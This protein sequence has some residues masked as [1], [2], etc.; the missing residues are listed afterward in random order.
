VTTTDPQAAPEL[1]K[2]AVRAA[3]RAL[4]RRFGGRP[5]L[6]APEPLE[7]RATV[8]RC[9]TDGKGL[10]KSVVVKTPR[11]AQGQA[12]S[13]GELAEGSPAWLL[14]TEWASL[15]F[16]DALQGAAAPRISPRLYGGDLKAG[17][18]VLE[19]LGGGQSLAD[20][21]LGDDA[22]AALAAF[23]AFGRSLG[24]MHAL[25]AGREAEYAEAL[26]SLGRAPLDRTAVHRRLRAEIEK[27]PATFDEFEFEW[28]PGMVDDVQLV[29]ASMLEPGPRRA[30]THGDPCPDNDRL[31][32]GG[33]VLLDFERAGFR[34]AAV[35]GAYARVPFPTCWCTNRMPEY[36]REGF[37]TAYRL[38]LMKGVPEAGDDAFFERSLTEAAGWWLIANANS[39][40]PGALRFERR[41]GIST[42]RQRLLYRFE[43]FSRLS[44]KSG[45]LEALG[46]WAWLM[47]ERMKVLWPEVQDMPVYPAFRKSAAE[48]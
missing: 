43:E 8:F 36:V 3:E 46:T 31:L 32:D 45:Y 14:T 48:S 47:H 7:E 15:E 34:S 20:A 19:D 26:E 16:L 21:L 11:P 18:L 40:L 30:L 12:Y 38:E 29:A 10:P 35:D 22:A 6:L 37:E 9:L 24:R 44:A 28:S 13:A 4:R 33:M 23:T 5:R 1:P 42:V 41:W 25:T 27:L 17:V 2:D 39:L